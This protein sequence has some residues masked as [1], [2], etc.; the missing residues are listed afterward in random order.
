MYATNAKGYAKAIQSLADDLRKDYD[1]TTQFSGTGPAEYSTY[2]ENF[3]NVIFRLNTE[4][5]RVGGK[6]W[7]ETIEPQ[8][9]LKGT[10]HIRLTVSMPPEELSSP[11]PHRPARGEEERSEMDLC[12]VNEDVASEEKWAVDQAL[13]GLQKPLIVHNR[14]LSDEALGSYAC[15]PAEWN[16]IPLTE[17][18][19]LERGIRK[20]GGDPKPDSEGFDEALHAMRQ[21]A[22]TLTS[23]VEIFREGSLNMNS[24]GVIKLVRN[25]IAEITLSRFKRVQRVGGRALSYANSILHG[26]KEPAHAKKTMEEVANSMKLQA[27]IA[28]Q[29]REPKSKKGKPIDKGENF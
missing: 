14:I 4:N 16:N 7:I 8:L 3:Y 25:T 2:I 26:V 17:L 13:K 6:S 24:P 9:R 27:T 21:T 28:K 15:D 20:F 23:I 11:T 10:S 22:K 5:P 29:Q 19:R 12:S 1:R 18:H